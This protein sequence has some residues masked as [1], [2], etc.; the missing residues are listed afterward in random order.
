MDPKAD[1][2]CCQLVSRGRKLAIRDS[3]PSSECMMSYAH[4]SK[5]ETFLSYPCGLLSINVFIADDGR[6][7]TPKK[8]FII[9]FFT[10]MRKKVI[11]ILDLRANEW[12]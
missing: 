11:V 3:C 6:I 2:W 5:T 9:L 8:S 12:D 4:G 7:S 1:L 10:L